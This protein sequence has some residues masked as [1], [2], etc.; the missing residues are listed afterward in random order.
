MT[1]EEVVTRAATIVCARIYSAP[2]QKRQAPK[3]TWAA[4]A[5]GSAAAGVIMTLYP[6]LGFRRR[7]QARKALTA[8]K[9]Q[10][11]SVVAGSIADAMILYRKAGYSQADIMELFQVGKST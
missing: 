4:Q 10:G 5:K 1:E 8:W 6:W 7:E 11:Y 9:R 3:P 2:T